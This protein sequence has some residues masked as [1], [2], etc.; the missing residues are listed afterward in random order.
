VSRRTI[1]TSLY[2]GDEPVENQDGRVLE[3]GAGGEIDD[4]GVNE[5]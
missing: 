3:E 5:S 4:V 1:W 2:P